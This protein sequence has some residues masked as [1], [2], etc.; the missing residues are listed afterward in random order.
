M[1]LLGGGGGTHP[2]ADGKSAY[3][4]AVE[5]GFEGTVIEWL[6]SLKGQD[7][8]D[9]TVTVDSTLDSQSTNPV[10]NKVVFA[11]IGD[12]ETLLGGI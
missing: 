10:Q 1:A 9:A 7:G 8:S 5:N 4:I 2:G 11:A 3:E 6:A 12:I